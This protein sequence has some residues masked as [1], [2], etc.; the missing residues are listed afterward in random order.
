MSTPHHSSLSDRPVKV[1]LTGA[2]GVMG[3]SGLECLTAE[4]GRYDVTVLAR[5]SKKNK[6]KLQEYIDRGVKVVW[7]SLEI[8]EDVARGVDGAEII[9]HVGGAVSPRAD[10]YPKPTIRT[11]VTAMQNIVKAVKEQLSKHPDREEPKVV[12]IGSVSQYGNRSIPE[13]WGGVGDPLIP[14]LYDAYAYSKIEAERILVESGVK[15]WVSL[16]QTG[17]LHPGL[18]MNASDPI[19]FHVPIRGVFEWITADD[20]GRLLE[21]VC[22]RDV[23]EDFWCDFYNI[24]GGEGYRMTNYEF[25]SRLLKAIGCPPPEKIFDPSWFATQNFH[26]MWYY[27]SDRLENY[28]HFRSGEPVDDYFRRMVSG[29]PF[30]FKL[31][32][33]APA[34]L[35]KGIMKKVARTKELGTLWWFKNNVEGRIKASF[36]SREE[37]DNIGGWDSIDLTIPDKSQ[38]ADGEDS[39]ITETSSFHRHPKFHQDNYPENVMFDN[40]TLVSSYD[41]EYYAPLKWRCSNGH[42]FEASMMLVERGGHRCPHCIRETAVFTEN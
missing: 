28:L 36:G 5:P 13:H 15:K 16:R 20:S 10:W 1:F 38:P 17:I 21:K 33:L 26:G 31:T 4:P 19:S 37:R 7:G 3:S 32:P 40:I 8:Y 35:I 29:L 11:N 41:G 42:E 9:L 2:T 24:G 34:F 12:Y 25:E 23:P 27:D 14:A 22:H 18:L 30:Y 6:K 39:Y